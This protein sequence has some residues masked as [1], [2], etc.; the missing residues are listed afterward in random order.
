MMSEVAKTGVATQPS[1]GHDIH[2]VALLACFGAL[3]VIAAVPAPLATQA[4]IAVAITTIL[5]VFTFLRAEGVLRIFLALL[6][7]YAV[8]R[9]I[10][11]RATDTLVLSGPLSS[12]LSILL[13]LAELY[14]F[15]LLT[16]SLFVNAAPRI[17]RPAPMPPDRETWPT[18][19]VVVPTYNEPLE[20]VEATLIAARRLSYPASRLRVYML[21]DGGTQ[22]R[23]ESA[24]PDLATA[25]RERHEAGKAMCSALGVTYLTRADNRHA[26]AGNINAALPKLEGDFVLILDADHVPSPDLL[27]RTV[28]YFLLDPDVFLVQTPHFLINPDPLE[29]NL[30]TFDMMPS[31]NEMFYRVV[32]RGLDTW[33]ASFFCGSA[34]VLRRRHLDLIGGLS[35]S[36]ITEDAET[37]LE[38]HSLGLKSVYVPHPL[39]AG[40]NPETVTGFIV[41]R[42]RWAQGMMQ[43]FLLKNL[44][45]RPGLTLG[46]RVGYL[47]SAIFWFFAMA[48]LVFI[49][50][51][52]LFL[53]GNINVIEVR[54]EEILAYGF[55]H[56]FGTLLLSTILFRQVRWPLVSEAYE[57]MLAFHGT[58]ALLKVFLKP[59]APKF[60]VTPK[61][62]KLERDILS[63]MAWPF[64]VLF[65][66]LVAGE[67]AGIRHILTFGF[68]SDLMAVV[69][70]WNTINLLGLLIVLGALYERR[71]IRGWPRMPKRIP[72]EISIDD[73]FP[74]PA[75]LVDCSLTGALLKLSPENAAKIK[76][77]AS[78]RLRVLSVH[79]DT[80]GHL[81]FDV[82]RAGIDTIGVSYRLESTEAKTLATGLMYG[83]S[84]DWADFREQRGQVGSTGWRLAKLLLYTSDQ[85]RNLW[86]GLRA[87]MARLFGNRLTDGHSRKGMTIALLFLA[88]AGTAL[89]GTPAEAQE[90]TEATDTDS[91]LQVVRLSELRA[92]PGPIRLVGAHAADAIS[93][94]LPRTSLVTGGSLELVT[95]YASVLD[96]RSLLTVYLND[97][98]VGQFPLA[99]NAGREVHRL[100]L[101]PGDFRF[102]TNR[103]LFDATMTMGEACEIPRSAEFWAQIDT[104]ES[105]LAIEYR[106]AEGPITLADLKHLLSPGLVDLD[107]ISVLTGQADPQ[108]YRSVGLAVQAVALHQL[109]K[110][111]AIRHAFL[112]DLANAS[113]GSATGPL[114]VAPPF[115]APVL[116]VV[117][118]RDDL[119]SVMEADFVSKITGP[120]VHL[121][122]LGES[123]PALLV[124]S[125]QTQDE[126]ALAAEALAVRDFPW[127]QSESAIISGVVT[128]QEV[129][130]P[131]RI[132]FDRDYSFEAL[133]FTSVTRRGALPEPIRLTFRVPGDFFPS[134]ESDVELSLDFSYGPG[135][136]P[137]SSLSIEVNDD[138]I[139]G[140]PMNVTDGAEVRDYR[141][142]IPV[143][144]LRPGDNEIRF[145]P[146]LLPS[147]TGECLTF[148]D[149]GLSISLAETS[150]IRFPPVG[151]Y[152]QIPNLAAFG[153]DGFPHLRSVLEGAEGL[154]VALG[155][156]SSD[157][158]AAGW[159]IIGKMAQLAGRPL[160]SVSLAR[161]RSRIEAR[162]LISVMAA[163]DV[164]VEWADA[165]PVTFD[166]SLS[167]GNVAQV[168]LGNN[169]QPETGLS[170][171]VGGLG[172]MGALMQFV[173]DEPD[174]NVTLLTAA[175]SEKLRLRAHDLVQP[176]IWSQLGGAMFTWQEKPESAA[177]FGGLP[178]R[179]KS[180]LGWWH[181]LERWSGEHPV[182]LV[183][184]TLAIIGMF[185]IVVWALLRHLRRRVGN[186]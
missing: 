50:T 143:N 134:K 57:T 77:G 42:S 148:G 165:M 15:L 107:N 73:G 152:G 173:L 86:Q 55:P 147:A 76:Q 49:V 84:D 91:D 67:V 115:G 112:G 128:S 180:D 25:A 80:A 162:H 87:R 129:A 13:F 18:V 138:F 118:P 142:L 139:M 104:R 116:L 35:T 97:R 69:V 153:I 145:S 179:T 102:G 171:P 158:L 33:E 46:Q 48:R 157:S 44:F 27:E 93:F 30:R 175:T 56:L 89:V 6:V 41:Q 123:G 163:T 114:Q 61:A 54:L 66:A 151:K 63:P 64:L 168:L 23:R 19:D 7:F 8:A 82:K 177:S 140:I 31:E 117:A 184:A 9:Y 90:E 170:L 169:G 43:I 126:V 45:F 83:N 176:D 167:L 98:P 85:I 37:A 136:R 105:R 133:G 130:Y 28:G 124:V 60:I 155:D 96:P 65:V 149:A 70:F 78:G 186:G 120:F 68:G 26:K 59:R 121:S 132:D 150:E 109:Y 100:E 178:Q 92:Q 137:D 94:E 58:I 144:R 14:A 113:P 40:L 160:P 75:T 53:L 22:A 2:A 131:R 12:S 71:Q 10:V 122:R 11:W 1:Q 174:R 20:L 52:L 164:P 39:V 111:P 29:R 159:T 182:L 99:L 141:V 74:L 185:A 4:A 47:S 161:D 181:R 172:D 32:Q 36:T 166:R 62:E 119:A 5:A 24:D 3:L 110:L 106:S 38:L 156:E 81:D 183:L 17:R 34:A 101:A 146:L 51:P 21:D 154:V 95:D 108:L 88:A 125:G 72:S 79:F 135:A 103:I 16:L 127:P